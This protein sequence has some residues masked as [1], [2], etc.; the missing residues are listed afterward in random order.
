MRTKLLIATALVL[1]TQSPAVAAPRI[2]TPAASGVMG[3]CTIVNAST[4]KSVELTIELFNGGGT[5]LFTDDD[6][7]LLPGRA[8]GLQV[9]GAAYCAVTVRKGGRRNVRVGFVGYNAA[10]DTVGSFEGR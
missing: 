4:T 2:V 9:S 3:E 5:A 6:A 1:G 10:G 8:V 7:T